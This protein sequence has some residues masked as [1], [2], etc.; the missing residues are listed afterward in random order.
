MVSRP[1][2][3]GIGV[4][5]ICAL[6]TIAFADGQ[7]IAP[8]I[9]VIRGDSNGVLIDS[10]GKTLAVYGDPRERGERAEVV[11]LTHHRR[12]VVWAAE[13]MAGRGAKVVAP[14]AE[15]QR[16][17]EAGEFWKAHLTARYHD[18]AARSS[19]TPA[20]A[21]A[22]S[23]FVSGGEA[24]E[25]KGLR[26]QVM[27]T[28]GYTEG[29]VSYL[30][31]HGGKRI[32]F[33]GDLIL[34]G[35]RIFDIY[36]LQAPIPETKTRG[37]H[38]YA[39]RGAALLTSL[40][41]IR[42]WNPDVLVPV[43]GGVIERPEEAIADLSRRLREVFRIHFETDALRWYWGDDHLR[44]RARLVLGDAPVRWMEMA[45]ITDLPPWVLASDNSRLIVSKDGAGLLVDCGGAKR[46]AQVQEWQRAGRLK[47]LEGIYVSHYH[48]DHTDFVQEAAAL[49]HVPVHA[50][51]ELTDILRNPSAYQM[52]CLTKNPIRRLEPMREGEPRR[53][54]EFTL[55]SFYFPGQTLYHG[56]LLVTR[57]GGE[58]ILFVG[59]SFTPS[60]MD[61][62]CLQNRNFVGLDEGYSY[63]LRKLRGLP[64]GTFLVNQHVLPMWRFSKEQLD[65]MEASRAERLPVLRDLFPWDDPNFGV[66][67]SWARLYPYEQRAGA[68]QTVE[69]EA[70][71]RNHS[72]RAREYRVTAHVPAGWTVTPRVAAVKT[73]PRGEGT[74]KFRVKTGKS[75]AGVDVITADV[76][77]GERTLRRWMEAL[78]VRD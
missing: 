72:P 32:A 70:V 52:P 42:A 71:I 28:P 74:A 77:T 63:C 65:R 15:R 50:A 43:R 19:K 64:G 44:A 46:I 23:R 57:D 16:I 8:G 13:R 12:D 11:L 76:N 22:V 66:D 30:L 51:P 21:F 9:R 2:G 36:S 37:Y 41:A 35:G 49:F 53:W 17:A 26:F 54:H 10:G 1:I 73:G 47:R 45:Q 4:R 27:D 7:A 62:Y 68:G 33:T 14:A 69:I 20:A 55:T 59:D 5:L 31:E 58:S 67:E 56:A 18:Y 34:E 40:A 78:V 48:D 39:A 3:Y 75:G 29:A 25:W 61:D 38:G 6:L 60:G 24:V